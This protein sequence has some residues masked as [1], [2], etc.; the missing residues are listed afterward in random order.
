MLSKQL[1]ELLQFAILTSYLLSSWRQE[2][3][4]SQGIMLWWC[5]VLAVDVF[6]W[7]CLNRPPYVKAFMNVFDVGLG[8]VFI[9]AKYRQPME[10][11]LTKL[12]AL[13]LSVFR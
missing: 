11:M 10:R 7:Q 1:V 5:S 3:R 9:Y 13:G 12:A 6:V 8:L 4:L 2:T